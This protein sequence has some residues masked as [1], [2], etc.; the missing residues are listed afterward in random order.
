MAPD[1]ALR[2]NLLRSR[3]LGAELRGGVTRIAAVGPTARVLLGI[4]ADEEGIGPGG[5]ALH[6]DVVHEG[7]AFIADAIDA[8]SFSDRQA[9]LGD[10][11][12]RPADSVADTAEPLSVLYYRQSVMLPS[13]RGVKLF[14]IRH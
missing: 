5:A 11:R 8:G 6:R 12:L 4:L 1:I 10:A 13:N 3:G 14:R 2:G 9:A 7:R